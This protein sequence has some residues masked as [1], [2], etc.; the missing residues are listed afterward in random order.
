MEGGGR[1]GVALLQGCCLLWTGNLGV[2][3]QAVG[4]EVRTGYVGLYVWNE[5]VKF[6]IH[7]YVKFDQVT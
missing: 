3:G 4:A 5:H 6:D 7:I 2:G 1:T